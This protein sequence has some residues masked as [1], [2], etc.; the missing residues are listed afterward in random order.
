MASRF[1]FEESLALFVETDQ[2]DM[3]NPGRGESEFLEFRNLNHLTL[4]IG[5]FL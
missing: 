4:F 3:Q 2:T 1:L 5:G